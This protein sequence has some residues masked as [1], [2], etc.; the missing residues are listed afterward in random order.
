ME[1]NQFLTRNYKM[2]AEVQTSI[3][4][5]N[6]MAAQL[7]YKI[8]SNLQLNVNHRHQLQIVKEDPHEVIEGEMHFDPKYFPGDSVSAVAALENDFLH[9][10][11]IDLKQTIDKLALQLRA[12][13]TTLKSYRDEL[14]QEKANS[15]TMKREQRQISADAKANER[16]VKCVQLEFELL[17]NMTTKSQEAFA[18]VGIEGMRVAT[19][20]DKSSKMVKKQMK[21]IGEKNA[22]VKS[23]QEG[24]CLIHESNVMKRKTQE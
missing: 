19:E 9:R 7:R 11:V 10:E 24:K 4:Q 15:E 16:Y 17:R 13:D 22:E 18:L 1:Y 8:D 21:E 5:L 14:K 2:S 20:F 23:L 3:E 6:L 12:K